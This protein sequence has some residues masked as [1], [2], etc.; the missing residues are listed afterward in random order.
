MTIEGFVEHIIYRNAENAYTVM[1]LNTGD[2]NELTLVGIFSVIDEGDYLE[3]EGEMVQH[4]SYGLQLKVSSYSMKMP[5]DSDSMLIY[6]ASGAISGI[7]EALAK[8][9]VK[10]FGDDTFRIMSEEPERLAEIKGI[11]INKAQQISA[12]FAEKAGMRQAMMFLQKYGIS[13]I[14]AVRVYEKYHDKM[15]GI[16]EENPYRMC[17]DIPGIGFKKADEIA[18]RAGIERHSPFRVRAGILFV[19]KNA[20][21]EGNVYIL[22]EELLEKTASILTVERDE[23]DASLSQLAI[24]REVICRKNDEGTAVYLASYYN[25]EIEC[26]K[27]L[28]DLDLRIELPEDEISSAIKVIEKKTSLTLEDNQKSAVIKAIGNGVFIMT[29][30]PGTGKTTTLKVL[31]NFYTTAGM[32]VMLAAPTGRAARRMSE[33]TGMSARTIH[34]MLE[35][36]GGAGDGE[37]ARIFQ[38]NS[39]NPLETDVVV[40]DEMSMVDLPLFRS[41]LRAIAPGTRLIMVG[42]EHQLPS[43]GPGSVL[44]D[45][46]ASGQFEMV[47]LKK[48]FRQA[49]ESDIVMNAHAILDGKIPEMD[50]KSRDFYFLSRTDAEEIIQG[51]IYLVSKKLPPYVKSNPMEIQVMT[52]MKKGLLGVEAMNRRLQEALNPPHRGKIEKNLGNWVIREGDKVMQTRNNYQLEW[53]MEK[54]DSPLQE[55]GSGV[56][57]GDMGIV[58][59]I[60]PSFGDINV[61]FDDGR[62]VKYPSASAGELELAYAITIHKSQGSEYPAV[63]LPLLSGPEILMTRNLIYTAITRAKSCV[64]IIGRKR[65]VEDMIMN[66]NEQKRYT[67]LAERI[68]E[69][70]EKMRS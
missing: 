59:S 26:A 58:T 53:E 61:L 19:L 42:D 30:G 60:D 56:F 27:L 63:V 65:T 44:K 51:V 20:S 49:G 41:L 21:N 54:E 5:E 39:E 37:S 46:I 13:N 8:R 25:M 24:E 17:E 52:P 14:M 3:A 47:T 22:E 50:N 40:I 38:R 16:I 7:R 66:T 33:A 2:G 43:V 12:S 23:V 48:I 70:F 68:K 34:R 10:K 36:T 28:N 67:S 6:L 62:K 35:V 29:G 15:Y 1:E 55:S 11:S 32:S 45:L 31:L 18:E 64:V 69:I 57:N 9:I 4:P